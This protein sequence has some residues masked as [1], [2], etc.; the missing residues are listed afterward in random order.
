ME[1]VMRYQKAHLNLSNLAR[2]LE[3]KH[4]RTL[5]GSPTLISVLEDMLSRGIDDDRI[6]P[7]I[8]EFKKVTHE[9]S[10]NTEAFGNLRG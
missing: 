4:G 8:E 3:D 1:L 5:P 10:R 7:T 9:M 6:K 2:E